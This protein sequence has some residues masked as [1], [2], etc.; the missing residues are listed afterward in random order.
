MRHTDAIKHDLIE[1]LIQINNIIY[2]NFTKVYL[3]YVFARMTQKTALLAIYV[4]MVYSTPHTQS[5]IIIIIIIKKGRQC[6]AERE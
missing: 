1:T 3:N 6:R 4:N 2:L 5:Y